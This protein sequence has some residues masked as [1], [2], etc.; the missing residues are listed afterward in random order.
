MLYISKPN[1][2]H[3]VFHSLTSQGAF[4]VR[5][6]TPGTRFPDSAIDRCGPER[7]YLADAMELAD[8]LDREAE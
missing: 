2:S 4:A 8:K 3:G 7:D 1:G 5:P 6:L